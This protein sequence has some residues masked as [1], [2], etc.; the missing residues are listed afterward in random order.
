[1]ARA[2]YEITADLQLLLLQVEDNYGELTEELEAALDSVTGDFS[3]KIDQILAF[4]QDQLADAVKFAGEAARLSVRAEV[5]KRS[6]A[7]LKEYV[8]GSMEAAGVK[9]LDTEHFGV[10]RQN[11][12]PSV[13]IDDETKLPAD[14]L[15]GQ[16]EK[17]WKELSSW[18][19]DAAKLR[20][21][22]KAMADALKSG[23]EIP[24]AH[25]HQGEHLRYK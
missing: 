5:L 16:I 7:R 22:K 21:D 11:S 18:E 8:R 15:Y 4:A 23:K 3:T 25:L 1:M 14:Y 12:A 9:K 24:G 20:I 2:L 13:V 10:W 19:R 6:A 17:P